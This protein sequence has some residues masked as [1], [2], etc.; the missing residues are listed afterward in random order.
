M[1]PTSVATITLA[2]PAA[3]GGRASQPKND[4]SHFS[5]SIEAGRGAALVAAGRTTAARAS[6]KIVSLSN[7]GAS[8]FASGAWRKACASQ[9][10]RS[11]S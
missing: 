4:A 5:G 3:T 8:A 2:K 1:K 9:A 11:S 6:R 10:S 7:G